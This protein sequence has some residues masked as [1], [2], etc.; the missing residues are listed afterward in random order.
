M[1]ISIVDNPFVSGSSTRC[2]SNP[3]KNSENILCAHVSETKPITPG[4][5]FSVYENKAKKG[6]VFERRQSERS[7]RTL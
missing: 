7:K 3:G 5:L 4:P 2:S 6:E 1:I